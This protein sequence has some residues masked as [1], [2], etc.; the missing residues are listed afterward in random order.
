ML[1]TPASTTSVFIT[2][3]SGALGRELA[4]QLV[5]A[6][7]RVTGAVVGYPAALAL[8]RVG[9]V[10]AFPDVRR[11]GEVRSAIQAAGAKVVVHLE[12]MIPNHAPN[13]D[14]GW[15]Q[16]LDA[17]REGAAAVAQAAAEA[18]VEFI[19]S[20]SYAFIYGN[21]HAAASEDSEIHSSKPALTSAVQAAEAAIL[22]GSVPACVLRAGY[23]YG[24][25]DA[26]TLELRE[27]VMKGKSV[28]VGDS[29][30]LA[31]WIYTADL[32]SAVVRA[33]EVHPAGAVLNVVD[34]TPVSPEKFVTYLADSMSL[35]VSA[36]RT[37]GGLRAL[38]VNPPD[39]PELIDLHTQ[40]SNARAAEVLGW[41]PRY[42]SYR[43]G[44]EQTLLVLRADEA[45]R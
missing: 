16:Q 3:A 29:H 9:A 38:L 4:R 39:E 34:N 35:P 12:P 5:A 11:A 7:H 45:V 28:F 27:R 40:V 37:G 17:I 21:T 19:V 32:A 18:G 41:K 6:G 42:P 20:T 31:N 25:D 36:K 1:A 43:E 2:G 15:A 24:A 13:I 10:A 26:P 8:R 33:L 30:A 14:A 44:L 22:N 23:V